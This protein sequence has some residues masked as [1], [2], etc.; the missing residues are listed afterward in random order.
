[1]LGQH[2]SSKSHRGF[3]AADYRLLYVRIQR[4]QIAMTLGEALG[5]DIAL[6]CPKGA[7]AEPRQGLNGRA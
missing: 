2:A 1:M 5:Q 4:R 6:E 3:Q 7:G